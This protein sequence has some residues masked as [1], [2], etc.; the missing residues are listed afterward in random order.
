MIIP[1]K[2]RNLADAPIN[3]FS[4]NV[5]E[6]EVMETAILQSK[7]PYVTPI[8][9]NIIKL[10]N[11]R[12]IPETSGPYT[13]HIEKIFPIS[14]QDNG[15][16]VLKLGKTLLSAVNHLMYSAYDF[17]KAGRNKFSLT[18]PFGKSA[19]SFVTQTWDIRCDLFQG[20]IW[21]SYIPFYRTSK[22]MIIR[23]IDDLS[24]DPEFI[25]EHIRPPINWKGHWNS[26]T[27]GYHSFEKKSS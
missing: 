1:E 9:D 17:K 7:R 11:N 25:L 23:D 16:R 10:V 5:P 21:V 15:I 12:Y 20:E 27:G 18:F 2:K 8:P 22:K 13:V 4:T 24:I 14:D 26:L 19:N 6:S 3:A